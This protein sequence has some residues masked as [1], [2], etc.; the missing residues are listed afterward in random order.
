MAVYSGSKSKLFIQ[1]GSNWFRMPFKSESINR[2]IEAI[3]SEALLGTRGTKTVAP[4]RESVEGSFEVEAF[5]A[6]TG[7]LLYWALGEAAAYDS[8]GDTTNDSI[9]INQLGKGSISDAELPLLNILVNHS[10]LLAGFQEVKINSLRFSASVGSIP[11][12]SADVVGKTTTNLTEPTT[13]KDIGDDPFYFK[14]I[15]LFKANAGGSWDALSF[16]QTYK[17][18][19]LEFTINN[20]IDTEDYRFDGTG[21]RYSMPEGNLEITG[22]LDVILDSD[23][24]SDEFQKFLAFEDFA[25]KAVLDKSSVGKIEIIFPRIKFTEFPHDISGPDRITV[26]ASFNALLDAD[27]YAIIVI[28]HMH[29][30]PS[31]DY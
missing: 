11:S 17:Y 19:N 2:T 25:L 1:H 12:L 24:W 10:G 5:P 31:A 29:T 8:N 16:S 9:L 6:I 7:P 15:S 26:S 23:V 14:E 28:D 22:S 30:D 21:T 4:G 3:T 27:G 13:Y 18:T 20:N